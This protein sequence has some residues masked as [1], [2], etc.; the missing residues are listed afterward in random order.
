M[1]F[2]PYGYPENPQ[3]Y[4]A[5][6]SFLNWEQPAVQAFT[7]R[8]CDGEGD[9]V[10]CAIKLF[11]AVR[12]EVRY[13]AFAID[14]IPD[15][16]RASAVLETKQ[17]FCV[18]KAVLLAA[19]ARAAGIP[20]AIGLSDVVNHFT[21]PKLEAAMGGKTVFLHHGYAVLYLNGTWLKAAPAFNTELC[22][23]FG[24]S[25]TEFDGTGDAILQEYDAERNL[26]M[27]YLKDHGIWS[28]LPFERIKDDFSS[29]YP[30]TLFRNAGS[31]ANAW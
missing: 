6:T 11:Y 10:R 3:D 15:S 20:A 12:D 27:E 31:L 23:R 24:V 28:D 26:R 2:T 21:S 17:A 30:A 18:P 14:L 16:F 8:I 1:I 29:Y 7:R 22:E 4:L 25:P 9:P 5:N 19:A 13:D